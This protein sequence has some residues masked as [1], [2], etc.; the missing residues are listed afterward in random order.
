MSSGT[1]TVLV[2][3]DER[4]LADLYAAWL[5]DEY[6]VRVAYSGVE[7]L[8][9]MDTDVDVVLL[10]RLMPEVSGDEVLDEVRSRGHECP[11]A[12]VTAVE[13]DFDILELGFDEYIVK[14][15]RFDDLREVV[16]SLLM[17]ATYDTQLQE[18]FALVSKRA[19]LETEKSRHELDSEPAYETLNER[20]DT[21][22]DE[23][24]ETTA[25]L[26][27]RDFEVE[28]RKLGAKTTA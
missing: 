12:M 9:E 3:E 24:D 21:L 27:D 5:T 8:D 20:I 19:V 14:P 4:E 2:V 13:P 26:T 22:E 15:V 16:A 11:I 18:Y 25:E 10:D 7:A 23:L 28:L 1:E 6:D 17:R